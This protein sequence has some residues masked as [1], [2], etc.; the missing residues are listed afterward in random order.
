MTYV[1]GFVTAVPTAK[2]DA[3]IAH[4]KAAL[5]M[6]KDL[7]ATRM[8]ET[9]GQDV[10]A[11]KVTDFAR[12]V[13]ATDDETVVFS[14]IEYPDKATRDAANARM[15]DDP[16]MEELS[17]D[18][19]FDGQRMI[20]GGFA[21][22]VDVAADGTRGYVDGYLVPVTTAKRDAYK[23]IADMFAAKAKALGAVRIVEAWADDVP[24][25]QVTDFRRA[26]QAR[27]NETVVFSF[28]IWPDRA[29]RDAGWDAIMADPEMQPE[30]EMPFD[31]PRM[32]WGGFEPMLDA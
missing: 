17:K 6:F 9:W 19:P 11:G 22:I 31:G 32:I 3:Y 27:D 5:P 26:V 8:V 30:G 10:P 12:S 25:G 20:F 13:K 2:R 16:R 4:A 1:E 18:M 29:T 23:V 14:W 24:D 28:V 7:G 21:P 15:M